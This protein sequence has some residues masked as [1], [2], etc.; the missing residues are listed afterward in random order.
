MSK[1]TGPWNYVTPQVTIDY[2]AG[3]HEVSTEIA[4]AFAASNPEKETTNGDQGPATPRPARG[5]GTA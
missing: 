5:A 2:P 1:I 4:A 3:E